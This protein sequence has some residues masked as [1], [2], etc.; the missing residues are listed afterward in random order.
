MQRYRLFLELPLILLSSVVIDLI[1]KEN[2]EVP[3]KKMIDIAAKD[4]LINRHPFFFKFSFI[5]KE[6]FST[7][8]EGVWRNMLISPY[9]RGGTQS[10]PPVGSSEKQRKSTENLEEDRW[11]DRHS[12]SSHP[13]RTQKQLNVPVITAPSPPSL[14]S[15]LLLLLRQEG[16]EIITNILL[17]TTLTH[18]QFSFLHLRLRELRHLEC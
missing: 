17:H 14:P 1:M 4:S 9:L 7:T 3:S 16:R 12:A 11:C 6:E 2:N 13:T 5:R 8:T 10:G 18:S 15:S